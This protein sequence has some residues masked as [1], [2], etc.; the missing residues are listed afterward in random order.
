[1]AELLTDMKLISKRNEGF[2]EWLDFDKMRKEGIEYIAQLS[3]KIWT[4]HN[5]HDPGITIL[6]ML[7]YALLDLGYRTSLPA[8]HWRGRRT[9][10]MDLDL[11][12]SAKS[13]KSADVLFLR[14]LRMMNLRHQIV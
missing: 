11:P 2:P 6:E 5:V 13:A 12:Q 4:D 14:N 9:R 8:D 3:G 1:M 7:C 10:S